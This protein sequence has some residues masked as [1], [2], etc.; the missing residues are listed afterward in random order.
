MDPAIR[1]GILWRAEEG[2]GVR[3]GLCAHNC[4]IPQGS[5][6]IC[7]VRENVGGTLMTLVYGRLVAGNVDP[8]EKKPLFQY[9]PGTLSYSIATA[10]CNLKCAH[11]QNFAISQ[12]ERKAPVPGTFVSAEDTVQTALVNGAASVSYTYTEPT[13]FMEYA[14]D[15]MKLAR[16]EGLGNV[17]VSNGFMTARAAEKL[18]G[19]LDAANIDLKAMT[20]DF[21]R[22][23]CGARLA[24]VLDTIRTLKQMGVWV[25]LTTL[26]IPGHNDSEDELKRAAGFILEVGEEIPWHVTGF[27]PT[28]K[29]TD[30][31]A[32]PAATLER[33]RRIGLDAGLRYVYQGNRPGS[34][35][36]DTNCP[37]CGETVI[38]RRGFSIFEDKLGPGGTCP[39]CKAKLDG[40]Y[41]KRD[42]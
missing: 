31:G 36:E 27:Y 6:G 28:Y 2:G 35:G 11:C 22:R 33:A 5:R 39:F 25:E 26:I 20:E 9:L 37:G 3:C 10:G 32:T 4:A 7:G 34:G 13:I 40:R 42:K 29:L 17:F 41:G 15:V 8:I 24:P 30:V 18:H 14:L 1:D 23:V 38:S 12:L 19:L 16:E 21:Y